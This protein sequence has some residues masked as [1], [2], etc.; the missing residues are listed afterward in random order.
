MSRIALKSTRFV[1]CV[2]NL[3]RKYSKGRRL[4]RCH[5]CGCTTHPS[6]TVQNKTL[7]QVPAGNI[8][9]GGHVRR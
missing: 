1:L 3:D 6:L 4:A 7:K 5:E 9:N 8:S 2:S